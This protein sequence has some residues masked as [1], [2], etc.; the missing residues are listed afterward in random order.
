MIEF[1]LPQ[2]LL[3]FS[4]VKGSVT[5]YHHLFPGLEMTQKKDHPLFLLYWLI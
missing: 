3:F 1:Y 5:I 2:N 4:D